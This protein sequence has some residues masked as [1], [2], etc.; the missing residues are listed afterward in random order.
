MNWQLRIFSFV[1]S[2]VVLFTTVAHSQNAD[3]LKEEDLKE[4]ERISKYQEY[5]KQREEEEKALLEKPVTVEEL[6]TKNLV[7]VEPN[8]ILPS[9]L[10]S[11]YAL[12]PYRVRRPRWGH[13]FNIT[14]GMYH[15]VN[16]QS[17]YSVADYD[18]TYGHAKTPMLEISYAHKW[19]FIMGSFGGEMSYGMYKNEAKDSAAGDAE[20]DVRIARAG[21]K[22]IADNLFYE[23][24][25]APYFF[26]GA[27]MAMYKETQT[28][29]VTLEGT[30]GVG[31]Y[32]G[33]GVLFQLGWIDPAAAVDAYTESGIENTYLF[34]EARQYMETTE[35]ND[36]D[37]S[38]DI[39]FNIGIS[40]EF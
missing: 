21:V 33:G 13:M 22:Y 29:A 40:V 34:A 3:R 9:D 6:E 27:Y 1:M 14:V 17:D 10:V 32:Y 2:C 18:E 24:I 4:Q 37:F 30:T 39:D 11:T 28:A 15:P 5:L 8:N 7:E 19:N 16:Y 12:V 25:W 35:E 36:P 38:T 20:L 31:F 26:G 23:P